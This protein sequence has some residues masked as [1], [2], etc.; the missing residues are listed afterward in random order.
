MFLA[1]HHETRA[2]HLG[3]HAVSLHRLDWRGGDF[4]IVRAG[5]VLAFFS[6]QPRLD[7][8]CGFGDSLG[9]LLPTRIRA[10]TVLA[11]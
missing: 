8:N 1:R 4:V 2:D 6:N 10:E 7:L 5:Q 9:E 11:H 3:I